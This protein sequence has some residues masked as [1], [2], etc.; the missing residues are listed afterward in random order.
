MSESNIQ[1][2]AKKATWRMGAR[3]RERLQWSVV[4]VIVVLLIIAFR[5]YYLH[6][7]ETREFQTCQSNALKIAGSVRRYME[8]Y[9]GTLPLGPNWMTSTQGYIAT[10]SGTGFAI[11]DIF[12]CPLDDS[13]GESSYAFNSEVGGFSSNRE[14]TKV[15][16]TVQNSDV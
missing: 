12:H 5:P 10:T 14:L 16:Q 13:K 11:K 6:I 8:D 7:V 1:P 4:G 3:Q 9:D 2:V 15:V